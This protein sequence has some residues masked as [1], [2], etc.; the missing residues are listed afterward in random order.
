[1][2]VA[3]L[4]V[5]RSGT[6]VLKVYKTA[7]IDP[8]LTNIGS[9]YRPIF[10]DISDPIH[11]QSGAIVLRSLCVSVCGH[12]ISDSTDTSAICWVSVLGLLEKK[13]PDF[14]S[15]KKIK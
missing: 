12:Q 7:F 2:K 14:R 4:P 1:M 6:S 11:R 10:V 8:I 5:F 9:K 3:P 15:D 13:V